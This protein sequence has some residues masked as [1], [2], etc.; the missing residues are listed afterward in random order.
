LAASDLP[1]PDFLGETLPGV[2][3][4]FDASTLSELDLEYGDVHL[5]LRRPPSE[6]GGG[7]VTA[8][9]SAAVPSAEEQPE[10]HII[11]AQMVG[12]FYLTPAPGKPALV[13]EGDLVEK[14]QVVGII[15]AMKVMNELESDYSGRIV[16]ILV[17]NQQPVE[18][19]QPLMV[20]A[21]E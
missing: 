16:R 15:E 17:K 2:L 6:N 8:E 18:Y 11:T 19:G 9:R 7:A 20:V 13:Q 12:T 5:S 4:A 14:G 3:K 10:G 1:L 21:P